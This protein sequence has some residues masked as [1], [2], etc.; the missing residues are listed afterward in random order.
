MGY[1]F[2]EGNEAIARGAIKAKCDFVA[3]YPITPASSILHYLLRLVP[4][5]GGIA[6]QAEDEIASMGFCI[7]A[8]M[9]GRRVLT[10]TSG[11]GMSLYSENIGLAIMGETPMVIVDV[12]R[13]GPATGSA[14]KGAE[15]DIQ[16]TRWS[17]SGGLP[18][19]ALS[20]ATVGEA[21]EL[22]YIAFNFAEKYRTPVFILTN[23]EIGVTKESVSLDSIKLPPLVERKRVPTGQDRYFPHYFE[24]AEEVPAISDFG[25]EYVA[26]FTTSTHDK[27]AYLT[28]KPEIIQEMI[29]HYAAKIDR[30]ADDI[31][32]VKED[33]EE[34]ADILVISYG[35]ISRSAAVAVRRAR[36][37]G[38]KV[39][40]LV[41]QTLWPVPEKVIESAMCGV[42]KV[43]IPEMNMGQYLVEVE[44]LAPPEVEVVGVCKMNTTLVSPEEIIERGGLL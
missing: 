42:K 30:A 3:S 34:G 44:R 27:T 41:L 23:K 10:S 21:Y 29:D 14:T 40:S 24:S 8:S 9:A 1:E 39:S 32:L 6:I 43:I 22:T 18:I 33:L 15:S 38:R 13:Q 28:T 7:A 16:F 5:V 35:I 36:A 4:E 25:G 17:T 12:Q 11:P 31:A 37:Q 19:I 26:R 2:I 20:P